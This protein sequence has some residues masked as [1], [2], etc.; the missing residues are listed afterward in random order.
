MAKTV[1]CIG[2]EWKFGPPLA[3]SYYPLKIR[4]VAHSQKNLVYIFQGHL[5]RRA[6]SGQMTDNVSLRDDR[7]LMVITSSYNHQLALTD[8]LGIRT[9]I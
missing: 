8:T 2:N 7:Y 9:E 1:Y 5:S 3:R 6:K 4:L